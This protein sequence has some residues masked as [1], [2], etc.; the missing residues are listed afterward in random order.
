MTYV[1]RFTDPPA[2]NP[3]HS[4]QKG[5]NI[6][7]LTQKRFPVPTGFV[8]TAAAYENFIER[9]R[10]LLTSINQ[11]D[12]Q[13]PE[14]IRRQSEA[15]RAALFTLPLSTQLITQVYEM[16]SEYPPDQ[17]FAV[18]SSLRPE[19]TF[20]SNTQGE[21]F[22][23]HVGEEAVFD[24]IRDCFLSLWKEYAILER[25]RQ[26]MPQHQASTAVIVQQMVHPE[27]TGIAYTTNLVAPQVNDYLLS[28]KAGVTIE[29]WLMSRET[30]AV[31]YAELTDTTPHPA[32]SRLSDAQLEQVYHLIRRVEQEYDAP[33]SI[34]W[35][36]AKNYLYLLQTRPLLVG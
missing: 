1:L 36:F 25:H 8:V 5:A 32:H 14:L 13:H 20:N 26:Q 30:G 24:R 12:F 4:G 28:I 11:W 15:L 7:F 35:C 34:D 18:R 17:A 33:Q 16:L 9:G 27:L 10:H 23:N 2:V 29:Q 21:S 6:A 19:A 22:L 3:A 31:R